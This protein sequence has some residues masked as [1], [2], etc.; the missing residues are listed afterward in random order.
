MDIIKNENK[1]RMV[2]YLC[3]AKMDI[4]TLNN[5]TNTNQIMLFFSFE[6]AVCVSINKFKS[7]GPESNTR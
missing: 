4:L 6:P 3:T 1:E 7:T 2:I 5:N